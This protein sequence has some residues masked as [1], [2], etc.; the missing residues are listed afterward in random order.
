M[1]MYCSQC[2]I[3]LVE[4]AR[5]C[6]ECGSEA[7]ATALK[8]Y[9]SKDEIYSDFAVAIKFVPANSGYLL[10]ADYER[11]YDLLQTEQ[12]CRLEMVLKDVKNFPDEYPWARVGC[13]VEIPTT[14][15]TGQILGPQYVL[16]QHETGW[17]LFVPTLMVAAGVA[18]PWIVDKAAGAVLDKVAKAAL[19][20]FIEFVKQVWTQRGGIRI[21]H[22]EIRTRDKGVA[23]LAFSAFRASQIRCL[24]ERFNQ[25]DALWQCNQECFAGR[26]VFDGLQ[27]QDK[28]VLERE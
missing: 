10:D 6:H 2:G 21:D 27:I 4:S 3:K 16:L 24:L 19:D 12:Q 26:L 13:F 18:G 14:G 5:Y 22:V 1:T 8:L 15:D 25:I 9:G 17:E 7:P 11:F 20:R 23:R 28:Y